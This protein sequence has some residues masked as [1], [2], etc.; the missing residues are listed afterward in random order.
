MQWLANFGAG[1]LCYLEL[2]LVLS[3]QMASN[4][5]V[6]P[7]H[8]GRNFMRSAMQLTWHHSTTVQI[9]DQPMDHGFEYLI[10]FDL[11]HLSRRQAGRRHRTQI[12]PQSRL[13]AVCNRDQLFLEKAFLS[14][15]V[16]WN[17][18]ELLERAVK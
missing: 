17:W 12:Y 13:D 4:F 8:Y 6:R 2:A 5:P 1:R 9:S 10:H 15:Q 14:E 16:L 11:T 7:G 3:C 18:R